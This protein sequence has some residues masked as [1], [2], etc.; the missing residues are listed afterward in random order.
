VAQTEHKAPSEFGFGLD[1]ARTTDIEI[2]IGQMMLEAQKTAL[3][4][5]VQLQN[6]IATVESF[7]SGIHD[8]NTRV[9]QVL[10]GATGQD[11][12]EDREAWKRW[13]V[14]QLGYAYRT[15]QEQPV[16]TFVQNVPLEYQPQ[17]VLIPVTTSEE[18]TGFHR[19]SCFGAGTMVRTLR[20]LEAIENLRVGDQVL[21]QKLVTGA[22]AYQPI[23][24]VHH[25]PPSKTFLIKVAGETI[26]SS[27]FHR[28]WKAGRGWV[29]ARDL[30]PG[31]TF[32]LLDGLAAVESVESGPVQPVFNLDI[33]EDHDFFVGAGGVLVH[34][35]TLP[36]LRLAPFDAEP[37]L[38]ALRPSAR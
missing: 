6:D 35:N 28:F 20:G 26:V 3:M 10:S 34:D 9:A 31:D 1:A 37:S 24:V 4:A 36:S 29:M 14:N 23:L 33:A 19:L 2:P 15:P 22:L 17:P 21:S 7:N 32:R 13:W 16:P 12:G 11:F 5:Q 8:V 30:K 38:A 18:I 25:N 27:P